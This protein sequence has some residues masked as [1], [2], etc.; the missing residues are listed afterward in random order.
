MKKYSKIL[1]A[2]LSAASLGAVATPAYA[3]TST[4]AQTNTPVFVRDSGIVSVANGNGATVYV[5]PGVGAT[6]RTLPVYSNWKTSGYSVVNGVKWF[7]VGTNQWISSEQTNYSKTNTSPIYYGAKN[8]S[9]VV[10]INYV[11]G[12][13]VAVWSQ[14]G[15]G[16]IP[17]KTLKHGTSW[18][19]FQTANVQGTLWYNLGGNQWV[20]SQY[21][22]S[23]NPYATAKSTIA[24]RFVTRIT[25]TKGAKIY[26]N[27]NSPQTTGRVLPKGSR[28]KVFKEL[29]NGTLWYN[30]G[31]NQW[32][33]ASDTY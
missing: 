24:K 12:Y 31:G 19:Y 18:K 11:P 20:S 6:N 14:P 13:G 26:A 16:V 29:N 8:A 5:K 10:K 27:P 3:A 30:L 32:I 17:G 9:G 2:A 4:Q 33:N 7:N 23:N 21:A 1:T 15:H 22:I 28:W 25:N